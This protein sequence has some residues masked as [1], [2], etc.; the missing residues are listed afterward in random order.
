MSWKALKSL[1]L[2]PGCRLSAAESV[3]V[4]ASFSTACSSRVQ[5]IW[6]VQVALLQGLTDAAADQAAATSSSSILTGDTS[7]A[8]QW[9]KQQANSLAAQT[10]LPVVNDLPESELM[11]LPDVMTRVA[12]QASL[13][14]DPAAAATV[15]TATAA[16]AAPHTALV[17]ADQQKA[18]DTRQQSA[19]EASTAERDQHIRVDDNAAFPQPVT[20]LEWEQQLQVCS[21]LS[22]VHDIR[23]A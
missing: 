5:G 7:K 17:Q 15:A 8:Q 13:T 20:W 22:C 12:H 4:Q 2:P 11:F 3:K 18:S 16:A 23:K 21:H 6:V 10:S 9:I 14:T 19:P 1:L